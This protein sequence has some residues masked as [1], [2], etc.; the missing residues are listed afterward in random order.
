[1][2]VNELLNKAVLVINERINVY[3]INF[4]R[5]LSINDSRHRISDC[6]IVFYYE[7][8][9]EKTNFCITVYD[10]NKNYGPQSILDKL[11][12]QVREILEKSKD[13]KELDL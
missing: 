1:M 10:H 7:K 4:E 8:N 13:L 2:K 6:L 11:E 5:R 12:L 9:L 3:S